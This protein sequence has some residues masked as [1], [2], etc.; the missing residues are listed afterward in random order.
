MTD[1]GF[2]VSGRRK[3]KGFKLEVKVLKLIKLE[4]LKG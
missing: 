1:R 3:E 4:K 2:K